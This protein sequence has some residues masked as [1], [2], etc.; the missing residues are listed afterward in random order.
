MVR[1]DSVLTLPRPCTAD[2]ILIIIT[3]LKLMCYHRGSSSSRPGDKTVPP[4][5]PSTGGGGAAYPPPPPPAHPPVGGLLEG[6][7]EEGGSL[8]LEL[9]TLRDHLQRLT[10]DNQVTYATLS[11]TWCIGWHTAHVFANGTLSATQN[12]ECHT[13]H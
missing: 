13:K 11:G 12:T 6:R 5:A 10:D 7:G 1:I 4:S 3:K 2:S 8:A 9:R